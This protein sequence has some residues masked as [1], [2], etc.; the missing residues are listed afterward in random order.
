MGDGATQHSPANGTRHGNCPE[1]RI[2]DESRPDH[3]I[4]QSRFRFDDGRI[5]LLQVIVA[6]E[7]SPPVIVTVYRTSRIE[8]Y[9]SAG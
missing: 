1:Q 4:Y 8:K 3:W 5:Y 6:E 7:H 2:R 9:W